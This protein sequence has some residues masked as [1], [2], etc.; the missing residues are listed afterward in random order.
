MYRSYDYT[1]PVLVFVRTP[2]G[3]RP[4]GKIVVSASGTFAGAAAGQAGFLCGAK[5]AR[6]TAAAQLLFWWLL[7]RQSPS[8][9]VVFAGRFH[10]GYR[11]WY[12]AH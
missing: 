6:P 9:Q 2:T 4:G 3:V 10:G 1:S 12:A 7:P 11:A 8:Q 5:A